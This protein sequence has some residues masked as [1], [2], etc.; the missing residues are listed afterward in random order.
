MWEAVDNAIGRVG[1]KGRLF[2]GL[3][4]D[5]GW[6]SNAWHWV[7][8]TYCSSTIG[9]WAILSSFVPYYLLRGLIEDIFRFKNPVTR[10]REH[11]TKRGM[12][13]WHDWV[14]WL[15]GYPYEF[16]TLE[17]M[18]EFVE[19]RGFR[20]LKTSNRHMVEGV[21]EKLDNKPESSN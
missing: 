3:Y 5:Y 11:K 21:F 7:K 17:R 8:K 4:R 18:K 16:T 13:R 2:I 1:P 20:F 10:Y 19:A 14:D 9:R 12:S 6:K 15:G